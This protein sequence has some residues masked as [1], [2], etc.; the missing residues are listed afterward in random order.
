MISVLNNT[1]RRGTLGWRTAAEVW[2][3]R[4]ISDVDRGALREEVMD[5]AAR[6]CRQLAP[7]GGPAGLA[8]RLAIE[9]ILERRGLL[10][11]E[12]GGWC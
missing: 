12:K 5:K 2:Q 10:R 3:E 6:I 1:W 4:R 9:Q 8:E 11:R 7:C